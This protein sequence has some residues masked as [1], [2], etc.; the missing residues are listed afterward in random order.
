M[1]FQ[2]SSANYKFA[3]EHL[4]EEALSLFNDTFGNLW[5]DSDD[6]YKVDKA[7]DYAIKLTTELMKP[8]YSQL[9]P[10]EIVSDMRGL[11]IGEQYGIRLAERSE[12]PKE[13]TVYKLLYEYPV[14][15][16]S[17]NVLGGEKII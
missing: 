1:G 7:T 15:A 16:F 12:N 2:K 8:L 5:G 13:N 11:E 6:L 14:H 9:N 4:K 17:I 10:D 3:Y